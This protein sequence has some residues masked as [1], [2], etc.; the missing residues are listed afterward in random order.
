MMSPV[1]PWLEGIEGP[2][3]PRLIESEASVIRCIAGPGSGKT[4]GLQRR[5]QFLIQGRSADAERIFVGTF[6]RAI[7]KDLTKRLGDAISDGIEVSTLHA[8]ALRLLSA[9]RH[10]LGDRELRFL[11]EFE[12]N[13]MLYD[14]AQE[15]TDPK[16]HT[17][18]NEWLRRWQSARSERK[19]LPDVEFGGAVERWLRTHR[20]MLIEEVVWLV[21]NA[22]EEEDITRGRFDDVVVDEYQDLTHCE[23]LLVE[24]IWSREGS[25]VVMGDDDQSIYRFRYCHPEGVT[26]FEERF[27]DLE[28]LSIPENRRCGREIVQ[29]ANQ[30]MKA[31]GSKKDPM[32]AVSEEQ[33]EPIFLHWPSVDVEAAGL[34]KYMN[35]REETE[36]LVLVPKRFIG[37]AIAEAVGADARTEFHEEIL[38]HPLA[39]ERFTLA[40]LLGDPNDPVALRSW[41]AFYYERPKE[42]PK[43]NATAYMRI[44]AKKE[45]MALAEAIAKGEIL[46]TGNGQKNI[47]E[48]CQSLIALLDKIPESLPERVAYLFDPA[49]AN[50]LDVDEKKRR[51]VIRDLET[52]REAALRMIEADPKVDLKRLMDRLR[53]RI[54]VRLPLADPEEP[55]ARVRVMTLHAAKGLEANVIVLAGIADQIIPG[56]ATGADREEQLRLLYVAI[57]R[58]REELIVSRPKSVLYED[59]TRNY[60]RIDPD[61]T[62]SRADGER[63]VK[64]SRCK[65]LP[66]ACPSARAGKAWLREILE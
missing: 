51:R 13:A 55:P 35:A 62:R 56:T 41:L 3:L 44:E 66:D 15:L 45:G 19:A 10:V 28:D 43:R 36:F 16:S 46:V 65:L 9:N 31:A 52:L 34:A 20:G 59:A 25:L 50:T 17:D 26:G 1:P 33:G 6:T 38:E 48:R 60:V 4:T 2:Y 11:L 14:V 61:T 30:M 39:R 27:K 58:A 29:V 54:A 32:L 24:H 5:I 49:L 7:T 53:Y 37:Q 21:V 47:R 18:R 57:T 12:R 22:L 23:Q 63:I 40:S 64:L 42:A 8:F